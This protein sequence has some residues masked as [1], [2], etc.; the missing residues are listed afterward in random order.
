MWFWVQSPILELFV[1][2]DNNLLILILVLGCCRKLSVGH[3]QTV[4]TNLIASQ[5]WGR[6]WKRCQLGVHTIHQSLISSDLKRSEGDVH[7]HGLVQNSLILKLVLGCVGKLS[8]GPI[9][10]RHMDLLPPQVCGR[11][12]QGC[13][14][15]VCKCHGNGGGEMEE[16][17]LRRY[18]GGRLGDRVWRRKGE[19]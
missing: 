17:V 11:F 13:R 8:V 16:E 19:I 7:C 10:N 15:G 3:I 18:G 6:L 5:A 2:R 1:L 4:H 9:Q 12:W 14:L